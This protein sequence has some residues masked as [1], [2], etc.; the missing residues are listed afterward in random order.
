MPGAGG[1]EHEANHGMSRVE[2]LLMTMVVH[3][4]IHDLRA[5]V[6]QT[7]AQRAFEKL[8][9]ETS[10]PKTP[11]AQAIMGAPAS[12]TAGGTRREMLREATMGPSAL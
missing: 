6:E 7:E 1:Y 12:N 11:P 5:R 10:G 4:E 8:R 3:R 2:Q 9:P